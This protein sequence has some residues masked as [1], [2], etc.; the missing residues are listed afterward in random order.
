MAHALNH[1]P[2]I[3][4]VVIN[5]QDG[6]TLAGTLYAALGRESNHEDI[7]LINSG[8]GVKRGY[9]HKFAL[10]LQAHGF[11]V[12]TYD[13]RGIGDSLRTH[14]KHAQASMSQWGELDVA[15]ALDWLCERFGGEA[16][17]S[18][19]GHSAG[20]KIVGF[21]RN[22]DRLTALVTISVPNSY[23]GL[24]KPLFKLSYALFVY[25]IMPTMTYAWSYFPSRLVG[26]G[27]NYP[28]GVALEWARWSRH[29]GYILD[30][31]G[32]HPWHTFHTMRGDVLA[33]SFADDFVAQPQAVESLMNFYT[34][35]R[36]RTHRHIQRR[37]YKAHGIRRIGHSGFFR[38]HAKPLW[39]GLVVWLQEVHH[40]A[41]ATR[42]KHTP[43]YMPST[44]Q[45]H[46]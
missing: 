46:T 42:G 13:Y 4:H 8:T 35:A 14:I 10:Y 27:E 18:A 38:D 9:Y 15:A 41:R 39:K 19:I 45:V 22:N 7:V 29:R 26:L 21:A 31:K 25:A 40:Q 23:W 32:G 24:R 43:E 11:T 12:L 5:T 37:E 6:Y 1:A 33:Y 16:R 20:G 44:R 36:S 3:E 34:N 30:P 2:N 17:I 28:K